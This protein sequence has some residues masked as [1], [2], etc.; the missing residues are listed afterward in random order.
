MLGPFSPSALAILLV[1]SGLLLAFAPPPLAIIGI[2]LAFFFWAAARLSLQEADEASDVCESV[3]STLEGTDKSPDRLATSAGIFR[4]S[5]RDPAFLAVAAFG[6]LVMAPFAFSRTAVGDDWGK[7]LLCAGLLVSGAVALGLSAL[8][9]LCFSVQLS[10]SGLNVRGCTGREIPYRDIKWVETRVF[11]G[12]G[13]SGVVCTLMLRD[14]TRF[15]V[16]TSLDDL[17]GFVRA[18]KARMDSLSL[19]VRVQDEPENP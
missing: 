13:G 7:G 14:E 3:R 18:L 12:R 5:R 15:R 10:T 16:D 4:Y 17:V 11:H 8:C 9:G 2:V 1:T 6:L 19:P